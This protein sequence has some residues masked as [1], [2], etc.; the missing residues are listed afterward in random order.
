MKDYRILEFERTLRES[1]KR[2]QEQSAKA[3]RNILLMA[4]IITLSLFV[5]AAYEVYLIA[6]PI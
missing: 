4:S 2:E 5:Y 1:T 3:K 6:K